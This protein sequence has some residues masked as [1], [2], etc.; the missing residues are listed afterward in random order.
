MARALRR[1]RAG[2]HAGQSTLSAL[3]GFSTYF[4]SIIT[5][6]LLAHNL[7][8]AGRGDLA[9][10]LVPTQLFAWLVCFGLP[11]AAVYYADRIPR[12][13]TYQDAWLFTA[14]VGVPLVAGLWFLVPGFLQGHDPVTVGWFRAGLVVALLLLPTSVALERTRA[15]GAGYAFN[16]LRSVPFVLNTALLVG[17]AIGGALT[18][19]TALAASVCSQVFWVVVV[20]AVTDCGPRLRVRPRA[21]GLQLRYGVR[22][23]AGAFADLAISRLDQLLMVQLVSS[24]QLGIYAVAVTAAGISASVASGIALALFAHLRGADDAAATA[25]TRRSALWVLASSSAVALVV[26]LA[27][28]VALPIAFGP[29]FSHGLHALWVMLPGQVAADVA[30]VSITRLQSLGRPG[31]SSWAFGAGALVSV[32]AILPAVHAGGITGAAVVTTASQLVVLGYAVLAV[33][34]AREQAAAPAPE[35]ALA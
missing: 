34:R 19:R 4:L 18:L 6:P 9:A 22:V 14:V 10:V 23:A 13:Q 28:P 2:S 20:I 7:H 21:L 26:G 33:R 5:G 35:L 27:A 31:Q 12:E 1:P 8:A 15:D 30:Q 11:I 24:A 3:V 32:V 17:L 16:L 29:Q 25:T